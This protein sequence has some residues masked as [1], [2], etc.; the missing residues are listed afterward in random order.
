MMIKE[1]VDKIYA[2]LGCGNADIARML[3]CSPST[4]S[5][6]HSGS[7][8]VSP[9]SGPVLRFAEGVYRFAESVDALGNLEL[10]CH[11]GGGRDRE[12]LIPALAAFLFTEDKSEPEIVPFSEQTKDGRRK[13]AQLRFGKK[14]S[15]CMDL[16][17]LSNIRLARMINVDASL[18]SRCRRGLRIPRFPI[19]DLL[20][21]R[22]YEQAQKLEVLDR[23]AGLCGI[24]ERNLGEEA[25]L[26]WLLGEQ[27]ED[28]LDVENLL[29]VLENY[30]QSQLPPLPGIDDNALELPQSDKTVYWGRE[31]IREAVL[32]FLSESLRE[33]GDLYLYSDQD[34]DWLAGDEGF[35]LKWSALMSACISAG[36]KIH[37]IHNTDRGRSEMFQA[38]KIWFPLYISGWSDSID[39]RVCLLKKDFRFYRTVF[40]RPG[41]SCILASGYR[42]NEEQGWYD[43]I[44][45]CRRLDCLMAEYGLLLS[46]S[47][48]LIRISREAPTVLI[49][50]KAAAPLH[51]LR[52]LSPCPSLGTMPEEL[53]E[54]ILRRIPAC[55]ETQID[56][57]R[58]TYDMQRAILKG[59]MENGSFC[60]M[61][62]LPPKILP[63][64]C[65]IPVNIH[66]IR[67][68]YTPE[69]LAAHVHAICLLSED[70]SNYR[71]TLLPQ[72]D[73]NNIC[74]FETD[75]Q[76]LVNSPAND[77]LSFVFSEPQLFHAFHHYLDIL[78]IQYKCDPC[79]IRQRLQKDGYIP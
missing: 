48:P 41:R 69:E 72:P 15:Q 53:F 78:E 46:H 74:I 32:R 30:H 27:D 38:I 9:A 56:Q 13:I 26:A 65:K 50:P 73:Y 19:S 21:R 77:G 34:M 40:L 37:I 70:C 45:D 66:G 71:L 25:F 24:P 60:E 29:N 49:R 52:L 12:F 11:A 67:V 63:N 47:V 33:E 18:V 8:K 57:I 7:R 35:R 23:L 4:I 31:G 76:I 22:L 6:L 28:S 59:C 1:N 39:S 64:A 2:L 20:A 14:L 68:T 10:L 62:A 79:R 54:A 43:Y 17:E 16:L 51:S 42:Q 61:L 36:K 55:G 58:Q 44:T 75:S 3:N 5:R